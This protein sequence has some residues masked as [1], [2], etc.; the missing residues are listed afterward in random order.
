MSEHSCGSSNFTTKHLKG[1]QVHPLC[2]YYRRQRDWGALPCHEIIETHDEKIMLELCDLRRTRLERWFLLSRAS[3]GCGHIHWSGRYIGSVGARGTH[4]LRQ[5]SRPTEIRHRHPLGRSACSGFTA[6][7]EHHVRVCVSL[8][9]HSRV[10]VAHVWQNAA[11]LV[12]RYHLQRHL[13]QL[14]LRRLLL[15]RLSLEHLLLHD[16]QAHLHE[17]LLFCLIEDWLLVQR[18]H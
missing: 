17:L 1:K 4:C 15:Q 18:R 5:A 2:S 16:L 6:I 12:W 14:L 11:L 10:V 13:R 7:I 9:S 3:W 8:L